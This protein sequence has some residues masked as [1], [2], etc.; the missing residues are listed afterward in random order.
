MRAIIK[1]GKA[2]EETCPKW[3]LISSHTAR[4]SF[5]TN[6]YE[7]G[8]PAISLMQITGHRTEKSFLKYIKTSKKKHAEIVRKH[9]N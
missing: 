1:G 9:L 2:F 5:A 8:T 3:Q 7:R 4:R 6:A